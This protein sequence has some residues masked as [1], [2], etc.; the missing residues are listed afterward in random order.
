MALNIIIVDYGM[1]NLRSIQKRYERGGLCAGISS[2]PNVIEKAGK[3][4]L[5]GVGHFANAVKNIKALGLWDVLNYKALEE[6]I[7]IL[8]ICLGMQ[9]LAKHSE[10]GNAAGF[11]WIDADVARFCVQDKFK[12]KV[13]HTGWNNAVIQKENPLFKGTNETQK[14]YFVHSY[15]FVSCE[16]SDILSKTEYEYSFVSSV[17]KDNIFGV[18]FH[19]EKSHD[20]GDVLLKNFYNL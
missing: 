5:P 9:L 10:E 19:P 15:H 16:E 14:Y 3:L 13:P 4:I 11:G 17:W 6:K 18:Q 12:Y 20:Q 8:G 1:G 7:P 2:D